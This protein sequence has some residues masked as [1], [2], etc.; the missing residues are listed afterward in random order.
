MTGADGERELLRRTVE[1]LLAGHCTPAR[2]AAAAAGSG[3]DA[4]LWQALA[5]TGLTLAGSPEEAGGSGGDLY[6]AADIAAAAGAAAAPVP[7]AETLAAGMLLGRAGLAIPSG[8]LTV[9]VAS[10]PGLRRV[11]YGRLATTVAAGSGGD[12][13]W[14]AVI[15]SAG[16]DGTGRNLADEPRDEVILGGDAE[17]HDAP[18]GTAEY[19]RRLLRLFR[20]LL[21]AGAAQRALDLTVTYVQEREQFG[22]PLARFPTVQQELARMAGEV[23]LIGAATQAAVA[24]EAPAAGGAVS[25]VVAAKAQASSGAGV[26]AAIAHQLHGAIGTTQEHRLRLTTTRLWSW[27]DEDGSEAECCA[28]LGRA[29]LAAA[30]RAG[31]G[32]GGLWPWLSGGPGAGSAV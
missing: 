28:E 20:S 18:A 9:A 15:A 8:P 19:A 1:D 16:R 10:G 26:V 25:A 29:A 17:M 24:A 27:R 5:E 23:A 21:I 32:A 11:P 7:L 22:R 12:G 4:G 13:D 14:L 6:A 2:V 30:A 31:A 3:W